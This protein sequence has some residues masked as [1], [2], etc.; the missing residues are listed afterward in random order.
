M[1]ASNAR[2]SGGSS[3]TAPGPLLNLAN[4]VFGCSYTWHTCCKATSETSENRPS[5]WVW[6]SRLQLVD[7]FFQAVPMLS[8]RLPA[9]FH[10]LCNNVM[11]GHINSRGNGGFPSRAEEFPVGEY[12]MHFI[13]VLM[14]RVI[15]VNLQ[16]SV[17]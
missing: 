3:N 14:A 5:C 2:N 6:V 13:G 9:V 7:N 17:I 10:R 12:V 11:K 4:E 1:A 8:T 15:T 16:L